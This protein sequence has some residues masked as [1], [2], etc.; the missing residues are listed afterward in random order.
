MAPIR[1]YTSWNIRPSNKEAQIEP[2]KHYYF[3]CEGQNTER[4]YFEKFIDLRKEF[5]ISSLISIEYLEKT[6]E[7][8]TWSDP[9]KLYELA[10]CA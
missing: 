4:W 10:S 6:D 2:Y 5:G 1:S 8:K 7:H 3:I 9:Q